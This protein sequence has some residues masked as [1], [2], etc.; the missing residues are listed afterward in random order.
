M[1]G[2]GSAGEHASPA[3]PTPRAEGGRG[4]EKKAGDEGARGEEQESGQQVLEWPLFETPSLATIRVTS[5][6]EKQGTIVSC[7]LRCSS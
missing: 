3:E 2:S 1:E 7:L 4:T 5:Y 6:K